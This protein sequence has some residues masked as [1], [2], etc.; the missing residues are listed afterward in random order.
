MMDR[1]EK[2]ILFQQVAGTYKQNEIIRLLHRQGE[3]MAVLGRQ[4]RLTRQ[5]IRKISSEAGD[6]DA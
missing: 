4:F 2:S 3:N 6:H 5:S 1:K